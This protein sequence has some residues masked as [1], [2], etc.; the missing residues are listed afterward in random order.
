MYVTNSWVE[1]PFRRY[2]TET[3]DLEKLALIAVTKKNGIKIL[4]LKS[5]ISEELV[6]NSL[7][8]IFRNI[9]SA[10]KVSFEQ[11]FVGSKIPKLE[12]LIIMANYYQLENLIPLLE[13]LKEKSINFSLIGNANL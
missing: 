11:I 5:K 6:F 7:L 9:L 2:Q 1:T 4:N 13:K 12:N 3:F 10:T 8:F